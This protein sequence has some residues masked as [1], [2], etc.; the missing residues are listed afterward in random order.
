MT[1]I[2]IPGIWPALLTP[3]TASLAIDGERFAAH[4]CRLIAAGCGGVTPLGTTGEGPSFSVDERRAAVEALVAGGVPASRILVSTSAAALPDVIALTRHA[5]DIG[6]WGVLQMPPFFFKGVSDEGVLAT[7]RQVLDATADRPLRMVLYHLPQLSGVGLGQKLISDLLDAY[8]QRIVAIKDSG[9]QRA[10]S[11]ALADAFMP[12]DAPRLRVHVGHEPDLPHLCRRGS[13]GAVSG[14]AN[15]MPHAVRRLALE[16]DTP[17]AQR[18]LQR[19]EQLLAALGAY[20]L[21]P[22]LKAIQAQ[23]SGD[24]AWLRVRAPLVALDAAQQRNLAAALAPLGLE[25]DAP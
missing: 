11:L 15:F 1:E 5:Q 23:R 20:A 10:H 9:G 2:G 24:A 21:I 6:A 16:A 13:G 7:Y 14:L 8:P 17:A 22:A 19:V 3:L 18:D 25:T 12:A 4:A